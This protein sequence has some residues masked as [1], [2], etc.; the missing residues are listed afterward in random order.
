MVKKGHKKRKIGGVH[1]ENSLQRAR[2]KVGLTQEQASEKV[3]CSPRVLQRY[4]SGERIPDAIVAMR[5]AK[6]YECEMVELFP[7]GLIE[8]QEE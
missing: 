5:M 2:L 7:N 1:R 3:G 4:E 6:H 8:A